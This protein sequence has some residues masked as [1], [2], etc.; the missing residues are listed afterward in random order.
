MVKVFKESHVTDLDTLDVHHRC[1]TGK[2]ETHDLPD[3][4][5]TL[6]QLEK[7]LKD[8]VEKPIPYTSNQ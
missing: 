8:S 5:Q 6:D 7:W 4:P 2:K 1:V 3:T